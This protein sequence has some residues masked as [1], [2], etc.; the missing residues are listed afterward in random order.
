MR[1]FTDRGTL[2]KGFLWFGFKA[3]STNEIVRRL[4]KEAAEFG[5]DVKCV[6]S[7]DS[8]FGCE[9]IERVQVTVGPNVL[10]FWP[11]GD[12]WAWVQSSVL[13]RRSSRRIETSLAEIYL[14]DVTVRLFVA[15][16]R[17]EGGV[18]RRYRGDD[19]LE[20]ALG[21]TKLT[22]PIVNPE[23]GPDGDSCA[24]G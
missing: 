19:E 1:P 16:L 2:N 10:S 18:V 6:V 23:A 20:V 24:R 7:L 15:L 12:G 3:A 21:T 11:G 13:L 9:S 17:G 5:L 14:D 22:L 4:E 8:G